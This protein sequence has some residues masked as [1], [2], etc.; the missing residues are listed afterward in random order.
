LYLFAGAGLS[1]MLLGVFFLLGIFLSRGAK[2]GWVFVAAGI[3]LA[4]VG[5]MVTSQPEIN[6]AEASHR[7]APSFPL[8]L[9]LLLVFFGLGVSLLLLWSHRTGQFKEMEGVKQRMLERELSF[10]YD[11]AETEDEELGEDD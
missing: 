9:V 7:Y 4:V 1:S 11:D 3:A 6:A 10:L 8:P 2:K 5:V